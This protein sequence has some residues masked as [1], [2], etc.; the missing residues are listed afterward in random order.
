V[1]QDLHPGDWI[2]GPFWNAAVKVVA[3]QSRTGYD[4]VTVTADDGQATRAYV[5]TPAD[6][7]R[8][9][10]TARSDFKGLTF[11]G[12]PEALL[13]K[14]EQM[15]KDLGDKVFDVVGQVLWSDDDLPGILERIALGEQQAVDD[16]RA[17]IERAGEQARQAKLAEDQVAGLDEPLDV[18]AFRRKQAT[19]AAHRL[20]PEAAE[21]F[22]RRAVPFVVGRSLMEP[23]WEAARRLVDQHWL[24]IVR[25]GDRVM[26][27]IQNP[28][29]KLEPREIKRLLMKIGNVAM[30][31]ETVQLGDQHA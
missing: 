17:A 30:L 20:S 23:E 22:F 8:L 21:A 15:R 2:T 18:D 13:T 14:M 25:L 4:L 3:C 24:Y 11:D 29:A 5:F 12:R 26:W 16:A 19:F 7:E 1:V 6:K 10:R 28:H 27:M 31:G 9:T